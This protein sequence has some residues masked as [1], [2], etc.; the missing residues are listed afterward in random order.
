MV[1]DGWIA[2]NK[3]IKGR[4]V[5]CGRSCIQVKLIDRSMLSMLVSKDAATCDNEFVSNQSIHMIVM[6]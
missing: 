1:S 2:Y 5:D 3:T 4:V 6:R